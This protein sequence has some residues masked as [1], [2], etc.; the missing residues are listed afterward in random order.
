M[1]S[2][3][4]RSRGVHEDLRVLTC[5]LVF[6]LAGG[7][8]KALTSWH[9][10]D[11]AFMQIAPEVK[12]SRFFQF[13]ATHRK[14]I[15]IAVYFFLCLLCINKLPDNILASVMHILFFFSAIS[16]SSGLSVSPFMTNFS[17]KDPKTR[18][19]TLL[20][21]VF[22]PPLVLVAMK[23]PQSSIMQFEYNHCLQQRCKYPE[24]TY[25]NA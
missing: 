21:G 4:S 8:N 13:I 5:W 17:G 25:N 15:K 16:V 12:M 18:Q 24:H 11:L 22:F 20:P 19:T 10:T 23:L 2:C 1:W 9:D 3:W 7:R 6:Q 14:K